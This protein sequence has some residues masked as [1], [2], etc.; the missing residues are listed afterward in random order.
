MTPQMNVASIRR[1]VGKLPLGGGGGGWV[2]RRRPGGEKPAPP[3]RRCHTHTHT[4]LHTHHVDGCHTIASGAAGTPL[5][6]PN[7]Y[8][9]YHFPASRLRQANHKQGSSY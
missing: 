1:R 3:S 6:R 2:G 7:C 5:D 9:S 8:L 4:L